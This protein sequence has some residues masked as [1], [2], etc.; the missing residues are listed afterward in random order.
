[1]FSKFTAKAYRKG[2]AAGRVVRKQRAI[3][4]NHTSYMNPYF[5]ADCARVWQEAYND[6]MGIGRF[7]LSELD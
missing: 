5:R 4:D 2:F 1:M 3:G 6:G 7:A